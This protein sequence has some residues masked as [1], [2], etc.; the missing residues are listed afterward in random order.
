MPMIGHLDLVLLGFLAEVADPTTVSADED[1][2]TLGEL[3]DQIFFV[4][5]GQVNLEWADGRVDWAANG[6]AFGLA[7]PR[8][9]AAAVQRAHAPYSPCNRRKPRYSDPIRSIPFNRQP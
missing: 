8:G 1:I 4:D 2:Y 7:D 5:Q 9:R 6:A 3:P